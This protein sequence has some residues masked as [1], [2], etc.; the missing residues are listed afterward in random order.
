MQAASAASQLPMGR[1]DVSW[2]TF[3]GR[4]WPE[5]GRA[6]PEKDAAAS[7]DSAIQR[8]G[9]DRMSF[10]KAPWSSGGRPF[11]RLKQISEPA[12]EIRQ[13]EADLVTLTGEIAIS[14]G[15]WP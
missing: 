8:W 2:L 9:L 13:C 10:M 12:L 3:A 1:I 6:W 5:T 15:S 7:S 14:G 11:G 4:A